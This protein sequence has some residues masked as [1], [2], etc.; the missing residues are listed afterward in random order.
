VPNHLIGGAVEDQGP[1]SL[2]YRV[3]EIPTKE[4][5]VWM[6]K[7][8]K[9]AKHHVWVASRDVSKSYD[10]SFESVPKLEVPLKFRNFSSRLSPFPRP[11]CGE[12]LPG[13]NAP[14]RIIIIMF[15]AMSVQA[16]ARGDRFRLF[17]HFSLGSV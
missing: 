8:S 1:V 12:V 10:Q 17:N 7:F 3:G 9:K 16:A 6:I 11:S 2:I 15:V 4:R 5:Q 13:L 14:I